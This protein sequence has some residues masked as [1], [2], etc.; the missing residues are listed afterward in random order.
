MALSNHSNDS[1]P[2]MQ[3][4]IDHVAPNDLLGNAV[5]LLLN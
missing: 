2:T 5:A 3:S 1:S 4:T